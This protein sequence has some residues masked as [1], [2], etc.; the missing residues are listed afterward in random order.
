M[1]IYYVYAYI[2]KLNGT[3]YYIGKGKGNRMYD[4]NHN[5]ISVPKDRSMIVVLESNL[6]NLGACAIERRMIRW[7]GRKD[8]GTGILHNKTDGGEGVYNISPEINEKRAAKH[9]GS[10]RSQKT[11]ENISKSRKGSSP[12]NKGKINIYSEETLALMK[13]PKSDAHKK[14]L[15]EVKI[16]Y[17]CSPEAIEI[18]RK[19]QLGL[20][21]WNNGIIQTRSKIAPDKTFNRGRLPGQQ[22][23][24]KIK[25]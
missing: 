16:G 18:N 22:R 8:L 5:G 4:K 9:R 12:W 14:K 21:W 11:C 17:K 25:C 13:R 10:K 15:S 6:S 20:V 24:K 23:S 3:P 2:R 1:F 7:Y 19:A